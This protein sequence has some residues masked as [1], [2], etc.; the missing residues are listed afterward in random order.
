MRLRLISQ[1][2]EFVSL[3]AEAFGDRAVCEVADVRQLSRDGVAFVSPANSL[4]FMDGGIDAAYSAIFPGIQRKVQDA[5]RKLGNQTA[6]GRYYLPVGS[7]LWVPVGERTA[8]ISAPTMFLPHDVSTTRNGF[9][10]MMAILMIS[11]QMPSWVTELVIPSLCCGWGRMP[12]ATAVAQ[13]LEALDDFQA[14]RLP[15]P[16]ANKGTTYLLLPSRDDEQ[17]EN[18]DTREI[19]VGPYADKR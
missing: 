9:W 19:G 4:G 6:L 16:I 8:L 14:G 12:A 7:A 11:C 18:Y 15:L 13:M 3:A 10:A 17:P 2:A 1:N 5:I